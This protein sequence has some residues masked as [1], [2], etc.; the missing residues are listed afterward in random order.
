MKDV[1]NDKGSA[2]GFTHILQNY[3][4]FSARSTIG[5]AVI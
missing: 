2:L 5:T 4:S 1:G 3:F